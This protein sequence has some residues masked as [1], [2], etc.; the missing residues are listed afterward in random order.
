MMNSTKTQIRL[1]ALALAA[2][3]CGAAGATEFGTVISST[4]VTTQIAVPQQV[5]SDGYQT[6][7][8]RTSG[9][10]ALVGAVIGGAIGNSLG[11]GAGKAIA[12]GVGIVSGAAI[13]DHA[14]YNNTPA[15][16]VPVRTCSCSTATRYE[17]RVVGY[18]VVYE[19]SGQRY[20]TRMQNDPGRRIALDVNV[21]PQGGMGAPAEGAMPA[22]VYVPPTTTSYTPAPVYVAPAVYPAPV[23]M[24]QPYVTSN[25]VIGGGY[26][27]PYHRHG[28]WR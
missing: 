8:P 15:T 23:Y 9:A 18:D 13:G 5:C 12:T 16:T 20:S 17:N 26:W 22:P 14:E 3:G 19:Y 27:Y 21:A 7:Q 11:G 2:L 24:Q 25:I 6:V 10:G 28:Y 1:T 4:P